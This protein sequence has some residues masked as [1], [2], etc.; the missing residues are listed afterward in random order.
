VAGGHCS[1]RLTRRYDAA[2]AEVWDALTEPASIARWL[3][4][5][6]AVELRD[7]GEFA[8]DVPGEERTEGRVRA[9][10]PGRLLELDWRRDG[11]DPS[12]VRFEVTRDGGVTVLVLEHRLVEE[13]LGMSYLARW[14]RALE[15]FPARTAG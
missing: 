6:A 10:E 2:P 9:L 1:L 3:G 5:S 14:T 7:G 4:V 12:V 13:P 15:R 11:E 8:I